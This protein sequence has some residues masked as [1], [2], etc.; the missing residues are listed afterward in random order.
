MA[1]QYQSV[2]YRNG[3]NSGGTVIESLRNG[4]ASGSIQSLDTTNWWSK[5]EARL[6][7]KWRS[8]YENYENGFN[9]PYFDYFY[10]GQDV[11]INIDGLSSDADRLPIYSFGYS[12]QQQKQPLYGFWNYTYSAMLRGTRIISGAFSIVSVKPLLLTSAIA[13]ATSQ[14]AATS[15]SGVNSSMFRLR[16]LDQDQ[17]RIEEYWQRNYDENLDL[18][19]QHL[20][21]VHPPFNLVIKYGLQEVSAVSMTSDARA[22]DIVEKNSLKDHGGISSMMTDYNERLTR[23]PIPEIETKILLE[24]I[25]LTSKQVEYNVDGDPL[26]ETYTF[27]ARDERLLMDKGPIITPVNPDRLDNADDWS[28]Q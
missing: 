18:G 23:H 1:G 4:S 7:K 17:R 28:S 6:F 27:I 22:Q 5:E 16:G 21:S 8:A 11:Q 14:R 12:I 19:Q 10:T 3:A 25:E 20:F 26:L 2:G 13:K 15:Q 24:N 9:D